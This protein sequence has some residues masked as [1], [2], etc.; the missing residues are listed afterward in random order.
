M[1]TTRRLAAILVAAPIKP[2]NAGLADRT[3]ADIAR[4]TGLD[5]LD[6]L[7]DLGL[8]ENLDTGLI[9]RFFNAVDDVVEPLVKH[10][11]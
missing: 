7:L 2:D 1:T 5:P 11:V 6:V 10:K 8:E 3:I 9:G 4:E